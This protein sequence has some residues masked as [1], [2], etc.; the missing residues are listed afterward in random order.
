M[1]RGA[2]SRKPLIERLES[3]EVTVQQAALEEARGSPPRVRDPILR[4]LLSSV[5]TIHDSKAR[6][7]RVGV[8]FY[9]VSSEIL[10]D[11]GDYFINDFLDENECPA[12]A[13]RLS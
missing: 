3:P 13:R 1:Y 8:I 7:Q 5:C 6:D 2:E 9:V 10:R 12:A 11:S 4:E